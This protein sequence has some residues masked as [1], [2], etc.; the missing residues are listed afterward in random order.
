MD[1]GPFTLLSL[2]YVVIGIRVITQVVQRG[3]KLWDHNFTPQDRA[4]VNQASFFILIPLSVAFHELGHAIAI[5]SFGKEVVDFGFYGFAGY[6]AYFPF[7]L[8]DLQQTIISAAGSIVNLLLIVVVLAVLFLKRPPFRAAIN[9]FMIQ[10]AF[11]SGLN[12]FIFYPL[13]DLASGMNGDWRQMYGSGIPWLSGLV[14]GVQ[15]AVIGAGYWMM[16]SPRMKAR[17]ARLTH[18]PPGYERG[19]LGGLQPGKIPAM[20]M[21]PHEITMREA[22]ERV[23]SGWQHRV[24]T[25]LQ[26][27]AKGSAILLQWANG[28]IQHVVAVR[29]FDTGITELIQF[30]TTGE[31]RSPR[32]LLRWQDTPNADDL[33]RGLRIVMETVEREPF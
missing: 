12:A 19:L 3:K 7:G 27:F 33:T 16:T 24:T 6:V 25:Q 11:L 30:P 8:S 13:L 32:V 17:F 10:F 15:A 2:M 14:I 5:W 28:P 22:V 31:S 23:S 1:F 9:E 18:V 21:K 26:R 29:R 4:L 20:D